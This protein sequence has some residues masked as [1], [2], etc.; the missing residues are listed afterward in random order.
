MPRSPQLEGREH[1]GVADAPFVDPPAR[2]LRR[3]GALHG[4]TRPLSTRGPTAPTVA[5]KNA[6]ADAA[7]KIQ[8]HKLRDRQIVDI[9]SMRASIA[10]DPGPSA[11]PP[12]LHALWHAGR[13]IA[14]GAQAEVDTAHDIVVTAQGGDPRGTATDDRAEPTNLNCCCCCC[15]SCWS[16]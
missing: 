3:L 13:G 10:E 16:C 6:A 5:N 8:V 12:T 4:H 15:W 2:S 1:A 7:R 14:R 9:G 11:L